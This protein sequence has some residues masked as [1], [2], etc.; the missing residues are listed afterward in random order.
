MEIAF[1]ENELDL[2]IA[3]LEDVLQEHRGFDYDLELHVAPREVAE[4]VLT[5]LQQACRTTD[6]GP[7]TEKGTS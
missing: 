1:S 4:A 2:L 6:G 5:M 3:A 7:N